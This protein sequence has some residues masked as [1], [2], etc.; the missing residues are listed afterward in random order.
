MAE[1]EPAAEAAEPEA[2]VRRGAERKSKP[3]QAAV[4]GMGWEPVKG[5]GAGVPR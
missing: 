2:A 5:A 1:A 4:R 3:E